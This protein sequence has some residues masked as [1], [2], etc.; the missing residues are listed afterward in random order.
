MS[1]NEKMTA[2]ADAIRKKAVIPHSPGSFVENYLSFIILSAFSKL[3]LT[4]FADRGIIFL[5]S[6][7]FELTSRSSNHQPSTWERAADH[8][9]QGNI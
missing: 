4:K 5:S 1:V 2:L 3:F 6:V 9:R 8:F 7:L